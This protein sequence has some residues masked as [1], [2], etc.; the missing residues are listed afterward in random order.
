M[1][2]GLWCEPCAK[3]GKDAHELAVRI[4]AEGARVD[5]IRDAILIGRAVG[6]VHV[7]A[8]WDAAKAKEGTDGTT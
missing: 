2:P 8:R 1:V 7:L 4:V 3:A 5:E 6:V